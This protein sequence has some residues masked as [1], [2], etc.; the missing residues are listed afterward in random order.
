MDPRSDR[1]SCRASRASWVL[2][3]LPF[4]LP[5]GQWRRTAEEWRA[6]PWLRKTCVHGIPQKAVSGDGRVSLRALHDRDGSSF[7]F[8]RWHSR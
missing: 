4:V 5:G 6:D 1:T 7:F 2:S 3:V 8:R